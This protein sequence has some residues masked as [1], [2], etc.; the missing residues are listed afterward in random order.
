MF[1]EF[2][3]T[4]SLKKNQSQKSKAF[5][6]LQALQTDREIYNNCIRILPSAYL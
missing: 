1:K 2:H 6:G 3:A 5:E 4:N